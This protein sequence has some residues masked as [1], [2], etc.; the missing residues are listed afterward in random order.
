MR[1]FPSIREHFIIDK[2]LWRPLFGATFS[3]SNHF[4]FPL[5][6]KGNVIK[7]LIL[8]GA[9]NTTAS[10]TVRMKNHFN[11]IKKLL[12]ASEHES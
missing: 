2:K 5:R 12:A 7:T 9:T 4:L 10:V 11:L 8:S 3:R 6:W 1:I